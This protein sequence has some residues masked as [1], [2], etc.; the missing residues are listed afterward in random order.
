MDEAI[1]KKPVAITTTGIPQ[2]F[3]ADRIPKAEAAGTMIIPIAVADLKTSKTVPM[4]AA[5]SSDYKADGHLTGNWFIAD[6]NGEGKALDSVTI[7]VRGLLP[8]VSQAPVGRLP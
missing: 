7:V 3:W 4:G 8:Q 2:D 5:M 1:A 6:S